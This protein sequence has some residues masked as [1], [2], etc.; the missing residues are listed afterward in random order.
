MKNLS[1]ELIRLYKV[2]RLTGL[3][4]FKAHKQAKIW[5]ISFNTTSHIQ[6]TF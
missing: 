5:I 3:T 1:V 6:L 2:C 4:A